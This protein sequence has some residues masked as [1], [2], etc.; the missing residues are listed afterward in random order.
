NSTAHALFGASRDAT[1]ENVRRAIRWVA[2]LEARGGTEMKAALRLALNGREDP[3]HVRQVVFLTD[4]AVGNE[5]ALFRLL[6][7]RL[8]GSRLF[9]IG[10]GS[11]PNSHFMTRA[12]QLGRGTFTYIG[13]IEEVGE[14]MGELFAKLESPVLKSLE[15]RWPE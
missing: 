3:D 4:G 10:I 14:R 15:V 1:R 13:R 7:E 12:A 9:T 2:S 6:R 5:A 8:G 11:A